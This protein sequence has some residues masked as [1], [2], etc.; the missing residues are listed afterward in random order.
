M[1]IIKSQHKVPHSKN[2]NQK[3][4]TKPI[5]ECLSSLHRLGNKTAS[6]KALWLRFVNPPPI[7]SSPNQDTHSLESTTKTTLCIADTLIY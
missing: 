1:F 6:G 7:H 5:L 3:N 2:F 4:Q